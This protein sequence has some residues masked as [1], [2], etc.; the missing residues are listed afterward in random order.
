[1]LLTAT[2]IWGGCISC[3]QFFMLGKSHGCCTPEGQCKTKPPVR[4][5]PGSDCKWIAFD[6]RQSIDFHFDLPAVFVR[7]SPIAAKR[8][9][10]NPRRA[11]GPAEPS[12]PDLHLLYSVF[13]I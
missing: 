12:P 11:P 7:E 13:L 10:L 1:L 9:D 5:G 3:D 4:R 2:L 8:P 6:Q